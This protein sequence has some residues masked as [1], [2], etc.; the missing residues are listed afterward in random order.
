MKINKYHISLILLLSTLFILIIFL[1][2]T[3]KQ[4]NNIT[5]QVISPLSNTHSYTKAICN[6]ENFCQDYE[7]FCKN[8]EPIN[9][10]FTGAA[11]QFPDNW[12]DQRNQEKIDGF[13]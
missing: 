2:F 4:D 8:D 5:G 9:I 10:K 13:C 3:L 7:I 1:A 6:S 12:Q 11:V